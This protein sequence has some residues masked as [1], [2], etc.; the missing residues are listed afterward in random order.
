MCGSLTPNC[1]HYR[2]VPNCTWDILYTPIG[3]T[4]KKR[5]A[6]S[7]IL[8]EFYTKNVSPKRSQKTFFFSGVRKAPN[9]NNAGSTL[10]SSSITWRD[11][12]SWMSPSHPSTQKDGVSRKKKNKKE[13]SR[14][15]GLNASIN[16]KH[17][18]SH[19][20]ISP[21]TPSSS[22]FLSLLSIARL[23]PKEKLILLPK[24]EGPKKKERQ[25]QEQNR[26]VTKFW[27]VSIPD[28]LLMTC[29]SVHKLSLDVNII[30]TYQ[31]QNV[32]KKW[33]KK[34]HGEH[35]TSTIL[36]CLTQAWKC[37]FPTANSAPPLPSVSFRVTVGKRKKKLA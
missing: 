21:Q 27:Q 2:H 31:T 5:L 19:V 20:H 6:V 17:K 26:T 24:K 25:W 7:G 34:Q 10:A 16:H 12:K 14:F 29:L 9:S 35:S 23:W 11:P 8:C 1:S 13:K 3:I 22:F 18:A 28:I 15:S 36:G 4:P 30:I 32:E 33:P 37:W